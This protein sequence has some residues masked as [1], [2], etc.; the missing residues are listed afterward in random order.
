MFQEVA[1]EDANVLR[2][3]CNKQFVGLGSVENGILH[4]L[5]VFKD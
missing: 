5:R 1:C 3:Y 4:P 2:V